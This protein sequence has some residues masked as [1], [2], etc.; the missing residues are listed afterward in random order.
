MRPVFHSMF[1]RLTPFAT[2][3]VVVKL[4]IGHLSSKIQQS[5]TVPRT[6]HVGTAQRNRIMFGLSHN[7]K[8]G[9]TL[10]QERI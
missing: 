10:R 9:K 7:K 5:Y 8:V 3:C 1:L 2:F 6:Q 4:S